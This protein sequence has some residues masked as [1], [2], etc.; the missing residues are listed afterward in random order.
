MPFLAVVRRMNV[1]VT[2]KYIVEWRN[3]VLYEARIKVLAE[4]LFHW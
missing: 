3:R 1:L 2:Y 4:V